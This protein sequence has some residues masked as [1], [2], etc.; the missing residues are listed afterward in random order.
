MRTGLFGGT[1]DPVHLAHLAAAEGVLDRL[2]LDRVLFIPSATPPH[3]PPPH[4]TPGHR[5]AMTRLAVAGNP[6]FEACDVEL[7]R[8]G[9]S[10]SID[11][12]EELRR[13]WPDDTFY[14]IIGSDAFREVASW[15]SPVRLFELALF[16]VLPRPGAPAYLSA[17]R[18]PPGLEPGPEPA[19]GTVD[20][21]SRFPIGAG[22]EVLQV[23]V[24]ALAVSASA[25]RERIARGRSIRYLVPDPVIDYIARNGLYLPDREI[26]PADQSHTGMEE[27]CSHAT[28]TTSTGS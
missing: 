13:R 14:F 11:T 25:I 2:G 3:R 5:L 4:A 26:R 18:F 6:R 1:F 10:Y 22:G 16:V 15:K 24:P 27:K 7:S 12:L 8:G 19:G 21:V 23:D 9:A 28:R 20:G 17:I